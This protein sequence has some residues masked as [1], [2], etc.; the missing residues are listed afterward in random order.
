MIT[1]KE[2]HKLFN[3]QGRN[4]LESLFFATATPLDLEAN[5]A[6]IKNLLSEE[7]DFFFSDVQRNR[8]SCR[9]LKEQSNHFCCEHRWLSRDIFK[10]KFPEQKTS[11]HAVPQWI[12]CLLRG[13]H[14]IC[15]IQMKPTKF[16]PKPEAGRRVNFLFLFPHFS[17]L[18]PDS[19]NCKEITPPSLSQKNSK[20]SVSFRAFR[21]ESVLVFHMDTY[22]SS[23]IFLPSS[24][25]I[26]N[27]PSQEHTTIFMCYW[28]AESCL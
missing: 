15:K 22:G 9:S 16:S 11:G 1:D 8:L 18:A 5:W 17:L 28:W 6:P 21:P 24:C 4:T 19:P 10:L 12:L 14:F 13:L 25:A 3:I 2:E 7:T 27:T 26:S 20:S 23:W